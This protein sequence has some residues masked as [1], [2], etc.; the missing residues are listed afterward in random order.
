MTDALIAGGQAD[1][2]SIIQTS[3][4]MISYGRGV[5]KGDVVLLKP[6]HG[7]EY[8][9]ARV[10]FLV[11][12]DDCLQAAVEI[13]E[14]VERAAHHCKCLV[15]SHNTYLM[16]A[17]DILDACIHTMVT[18]GSVCTVLIPGRFQICYM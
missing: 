15:R 5:C 1:V 8:S 10:G 11:S 17:A 18:A 3:T 2:N 6:A 9:V 14:I 16:D 13:L 7:A 12:I 4:K